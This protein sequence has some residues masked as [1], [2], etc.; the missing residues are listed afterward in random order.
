MRQGVVLRVPRP[1]GYEDVPLVPPGD[2]LQR[3]AV[4]GVEDPVIIHR[5]VLVL[6]AEHELREVGRRP[7]SQGDGR[8]RAREGHRRDAFPALPDGDRGDLVFPAVVL[9]AVGDIRDAARDAPDD[10]GDDRRGS[11]PV[12]DERESPVVARGGVAV[13]R[14]DGEGCAYQQDREQSDD[15]FACHGIAAGCA[16]WLYPR[17][18]EAPRGFRCPRRRRRRRRCPDPPRGR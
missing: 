1:V 17:G 7:L 6:L 11:L 12:Y 13:G 15:G 14:L 18:P 5:Q 10:V 2:G 4:R 9:H 8:N 3:P 16:L